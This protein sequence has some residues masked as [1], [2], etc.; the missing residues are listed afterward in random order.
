MPNEKGWLTKDE[1]VATGLPLFIKTNSTLP[2]RWTDEPYGHA[3]LLT[4]TRCAQLKMP[5]LR[6]GR[7]A[8]VAYRYAQA[9][10]SSFRYVPL[11]DRTSVF[12]SGELPYSILQDGEIMGSSS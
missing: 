1:A 8:V 9:A 11:Y 2:G 10:A 3:V 7:E 5:T 12:E 4:R 6:S